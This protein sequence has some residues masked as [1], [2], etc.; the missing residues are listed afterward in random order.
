[1]KRAV[2]LAVVLAV[3]LP[4]RAQRMATDFEIARMRDEIAS[5]K[6][7]AAR[8]SARL[9]LGD[10]HLTR[11][12][13][14]TAMAEYRQALE[15][16]NLER[17]RAR[18][19][20]DMAAYATATAYAA[21]AQAKLRNGPASFALL[22]EAVRFASDSPKTWNLY[23]TAMTLLGRPEKGVSAARNAVALAEAELRRN[24][25]VAARLDL[26]IDQHALAAGLID[27]DRDEEAEHL[28]RA[29]VD[30]LRSNAFDA[31]RR[32]IERSES[33]EIYSS[34]RGAAAA[35][36]SLSNRAQLRLAA[37]EEKRGDLVA[38]RAT[39]RRVLDQRSDDPA[40][41]AAFARLAPPAEQAQWF[42]AAF[43]ANPF[44]ISLVRAYRNYLVAHGAPR[45]DGSGP[46]AA[47]RRALHQLAAGEPRAAQR[48]LDGLL[49][50]FPANETLRRLRM[51]AGSQAPPELAAAGETPIEAGAA[52]LRQL[53]GS[54]EGLTPEQRRA[55]DAATFRGIAVFRSAGDAPPGQ[56]VLES[57]TIDS[58]PF[59]FAEPTAFLGTFAPGVPVR[60]AFRLLGVTTI[61]G[62]DAVLLEPLGIE[63]LP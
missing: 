18:S 17:S 19:G 48:T 27:T 57:G 45:I 35:Y 63:A 31:I 23:A 49:A 2:I 40:A 38:A 55:L 20:A 61:D 4:G 59:R 58:V 32:D 16:A 13:R 36:L 51:E 56:T 7:F 14:S 30:S 12:D 11:N 43:D 42:A 46:G 60:L 5:S 28:L 25:S 62:R 1:M 39:Y 26:A 9:N 24:P 21:L 3:A 15:I 22:E 37:L 54:D 29:V 10:L 50:R 52:L 41:L 34:A 44:S 53:I 33:F 8:L 47:M 6:D